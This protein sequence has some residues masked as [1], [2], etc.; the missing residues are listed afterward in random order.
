MSDT[1]VVVEGD[2]LGREPCEVWVVH[3]SGEVGVLE[4]D[5]DEAV[6]GLS[7]NMAGWALSLCGGLGS[8][9]IGGAGSGVLGKGG[10]GKGERGEGNGRQHLGG[11]NVRS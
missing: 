1:E 11:V 5:S 4:P 6:K 7:W 3:G 2:T 9:N 10:A 8:K